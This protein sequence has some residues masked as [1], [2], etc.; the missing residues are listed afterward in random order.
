MVSHYNLY[1]LVTSATDM[2]YF[3]LFFTGLDIIFSVISM[4][5][6]TFRH[7]YSIEC[8]IFIPTNNIFKKV[9][10]SP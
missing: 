4:H 6:S 1:T 5:T 9:K 3:A 2:A 8:R 7:K 10:K